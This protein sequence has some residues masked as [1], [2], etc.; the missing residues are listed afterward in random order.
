[1]VVLKVRIPVARMMAKS[2]RASTTRLAMGGTV[3]KFPSPLNVLKDPYDQ[4]SY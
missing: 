4:N 2:F 3:I 1:M